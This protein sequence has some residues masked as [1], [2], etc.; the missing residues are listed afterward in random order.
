MIQLAVPGCKTRWERN[1]IMRMT[2]A[3]DLPSLSALCSFQLFDLWETHG[4]KAA[5][6]IGVQHIPELAVQI[7]L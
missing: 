3:K 6:L 5:G 2:Q 4:Q 7:K 1:P